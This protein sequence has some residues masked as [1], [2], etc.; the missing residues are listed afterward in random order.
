[1]AGPDSFTSFANSTT[2]TAAAR[3]SHR[4]QYN[5][6]K[7]DSLTRQAIPIQIWF[8]Q[9]REAKAV[10][11]SKALVGSICESSETGQARARRPI[12]AIG[13]FDNWGRFCRTNPATVAIA[14]AGKSP[15]V[16]IAGGHGNRSVAIAA[17]Q[18][19]HSGCKASRQLTNKL[20]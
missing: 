8:G 18:N 12:V 3:A 16:A 6:N 20:S 10:G 2:T 19:A 1:M 4:P 14:V 9:I 11:P 15:P 5:H 7:A 17:R 13:E